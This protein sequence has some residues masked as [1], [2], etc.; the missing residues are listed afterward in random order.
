ME[1]N[2]QKLAAEKEVNQLVEK[3]QKALQE[4]LKLNQDQVDYIVAKCSVAAIDKHGE[5]AVAAINETI[6]GVFEDKATKNLY[7]CEYVVNNMRH[8]KT[9]G[10][11]NENPVTGIT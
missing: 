8:L 1:E 9:V 4:F 7:A 2:Q 10:V 3:G 5:L 6:R 11:I